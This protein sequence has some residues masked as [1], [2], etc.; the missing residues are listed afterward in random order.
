MTMPRIRNRYLY[1][2]GKIKKKGRLTWRKRI[3]RQRGGAASLGMILA[4]AVAPVLNSII[5]KS[6]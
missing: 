1:F 6:F 3:R 5:G 4:S 2:S